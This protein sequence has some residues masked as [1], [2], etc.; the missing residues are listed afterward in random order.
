[1]VVGFTHGYVQDGTFRL[2]L[3]EVKLCHLSRNQ[4]KDKIYLDI[5]MV[6]LFDKLRKSNLSGLKLKML[7]VVE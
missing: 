6:C 4:D 2:K 1:L 7:L 3:K 5:L